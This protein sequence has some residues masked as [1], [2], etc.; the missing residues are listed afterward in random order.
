MLQCT[1]MSPSQRSDF[2]LL[3]AKLLV[4]LQRAVIADGDNVR[5]VA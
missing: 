2:G 5:A 3:S 4:L 1:E